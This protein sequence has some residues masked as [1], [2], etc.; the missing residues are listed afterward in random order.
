QSLL[1]PTGSFFES[2]S[3]PPAHA[4]LRPPSIP[5]DLALSPLF[6]PSLHTPDAQAAAA[7]TARPPVSSATALGLGIGSAPSVHHYQQ[8]LQ[9]QPASAALQFPQSALFDSSEE[10]YLNSFLSSFDVE[11]LDI[12]PYFPSPQPMANISSRMDFAG[13]GMGLGAGIIGPMDDTIPHLS[14]DD[15]T[16]DAGHGLSRM[17]VPGAAPH[18]TVPL[19]QHQPNLFDYSLGGTSRLSLGNVMSE[20]MRRVSSWV[21]HGHTQPPPLRPNPPAPLNIATANDLASL[22]SPRPLP[23]E[24]D[25]SVKRKAADDHLGQPRKARGSARSPAYEA[26]PSLAAYI[27]GDTDADSRQAFSPY[28]PTA[29]LLPSAGAAD[30][31]HNDNDAPS[32]ADSARRRGSSK[33]PQPRLTL[34][35]EE[36]RTNHIASEQRRRNQIRQGYAELM[37]LVTT[38]SDPALGNHPGTAQ[39]TPSKAVIL[40]HAVQ[41]IR[42][43][44]EGNQA[45]RNRLEGSRHA[46]PQ[47]PLSSQ[48]LAGFQPGSPALPQ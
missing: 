16:D 5:P 30:P 33:K 28:T 36:R 31:A 23:S 17:A 20:E 25:P 34:T 14:L 9:Q 44:E 19:A 45:L 24:S 18:A 4:T 11:G 7:A 39:S 3:A 37:S 41:F 29:P 26:A 10:A 27:A 1:V 35:E 2:L 47:M 6:S 12:G 46:I 15:P 42:G 8:Q 48:T 21:M 32:T 40:D 38:L 22:A 43:L 13:L